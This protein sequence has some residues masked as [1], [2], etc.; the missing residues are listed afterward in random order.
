MVIPLV[1]VGGAGPTVTVVGLDV[2]VAASA[3]PAVAVLVLL[4]LK[5]LLTVAANDVVN[6]PPAARVGVV[7]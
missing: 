6:D 1:V 5:P 4:P 3:A 2:A 7:N